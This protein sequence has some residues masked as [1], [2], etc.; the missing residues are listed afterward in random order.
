MSNVIAFPKRKGTVVEEITA[1]FRDH[2]EDP[3]AKDVEEILLPTVGYG[4]DM[5][6]LQFVRAALMS[7]L[8]TEI[9]QYTRELKSGEGWHIEFTYKDDLWSI[10]L[11]LYRDISETEFTKE[12]IFHF[13][14]AVAYTGIDPEG[15]GDYIWPEITD[16]RDGLLTLS[17]VRDIVAFY[18][19][20]HPKTEYKPLTRSIISG[21]G[22]LVP[23]SRR[24][25][26]GAVMYGTSVFV[27][28]DAYGWKV[29][30]E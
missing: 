3:V 19:S 6:A 30:K 27:N 9:S 20:E 15:D 28:D 25:K 2:W 23:I 5:L 7:K 22:N 26:I 14:Y 10:K 8:F 16:V 21:S 17:S 12:L 18:T 29:I 13:N 1:Y 24:A 4:S 11:G